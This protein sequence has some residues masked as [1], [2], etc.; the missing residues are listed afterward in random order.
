LRI[1]PKSLSFGRGRLRSARAGCGIV[2]V[3][4]ILPLAIFWVEAAAICPFSAATNS[5]SL[6]YVASYDSTSRETSPL[7]MILRVS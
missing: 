3:A 1:V 7:R 6:V 4:W 2:T 5:S